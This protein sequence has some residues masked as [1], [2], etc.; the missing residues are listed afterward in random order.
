MRATGFDLSLTA[1]A[2]CTI[3]LNWDGDI[4]RVK[5]G[6]LRPNKSAPH[7]DME[8]A[9]RLDRL[10]NWAMT[11]LGQFGGHVAIEALPTHAAYSLVPSAELHGVIRHSLYRAGIETRTAP[12]SSVRGLLMGPIASKGAKE[13]VRRT[14]QSF[15]GCASW[16]GDECDAFAVANW[17]CGELGAPVISARKS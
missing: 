10:V 16:T 3:P 7:C 14:I 6:H 17:L 11:S 5:V 1:P 4:R 15:A 9:A 13:I 2:Y 12:L 8:R